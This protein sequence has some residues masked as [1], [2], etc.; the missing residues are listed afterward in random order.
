MPVLVYSLIV[1]ILFAIAYRNVPRIG[2][3]AYGDVQP[4]AL[5][6]QASLSSFSNAWTQAGLGA[7]AAFGPLSLFVALFLGFFFN[8]FDLVQKIFLFSLFPLSYVTS[9]IL[10][11]SLIKS[12]L[13]ICFA[14]FAYSINPLTLSEFLGGAQGLLL[15]YATLPLL[16]HLVMKL[17]DGPSINKVLKPAILAAFTCAFNF[18][19]PAIFAPVLGGFLLANSSG[20]KPTER[21]RSFKYVILFLA[22][23]GVAEALTVW[24][25]QSLALL[26]TVASSDFLADYRRLSPVGILLFLGPSFALMASSAAISCEKRLVPLRTHLLSASIVIILFM[27]S[28]SLGVTA[29]LFRLLPFLLVYRASVKLLYP[30]TFA[31]IML[32]AIF[33]DSVINLKVPFTK[34]WKAFVGFGRP[35]VIVLLL[36][37]PVV[38][39]NG[40]QFLTGNLGLANS[41]QI[42]GVF[43]Q[44]RS[45]LDANGSGGFFR[46]LWLPQDIQTDYALRA[47]DPKTFILPSGSVPNL[48]YSTPTVSFAR[49]V[50]ESAT[51]ASST[52]IGQLLSYAAVKYIV[53]NLDSLQVSSPHVQFDWLTYYGE[54]NPILYKDILEGQRD[55]RLVE[56]D[57]HFVV[58]E[59][60]DFRPHVSVYNQ[61][62][63]VEE[64]ARK[65]P[66]TVLANY[67]QNLVNNPSFS[68]N[69]SGW[70]ILSGLWVAGQEGE[71]SFLLGVSEKPWAFVAQDIAVEANS[72]F[73]FSA[74]MRTASALQSHIKIEW[75]DASNHWLGTTFCQTGIDG[76]KDWFAVSKIVF[77][78]PH[79]S[80]ARL[81]LGAGGASPGSQTG[82]TWFAQPSLRETFV[83]LP[84]ES[85]RFESSLLS[86]FDFN[87]TLTVHSLQLDSNVLQQLVNSVDTV[88][89]QAGSGNLE[90]FQHGSLGDQ[91]IRHELVVAGGVTNFMPLDGK[92]SLLPDA[93]ASDGYLATSENGTTSTIFKTDSVCFCRISLK[94]TAGSIAKLYVDRNLTSLTQSYTDRTGFL[95]V[96]SAGMSLLPGF[97]NVTIQLRGE[98]DFASLYQIN[99]EQETVQQLFNGRPS[100][101]HVSENDP[102]TSVIDTSNKGGSLLV[103]AENY[104]IAWEA[105]TDH[106]TLTHFPGLNRYAWGNT[107]LLPTSGQ[108]IV[109]I[110][111]SLQDSRNTLIIGYLVFWLLLL[112]IAATSVCLW[113]ARSSRRV[114]RLILRGLRSRV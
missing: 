60:L 87:Q 55:L 6:W 88:L 107:F 95:W 47:F 51:N 36:V 97:H 113:F 91:R 59:N 24:L 80:V 79:A 64:D 41:T 82:M 40:N 65:N 33:M 84:Y 46:T 68:G 114:R 67:T 85:S 8:N 62:L 4:W 34:T 42:D 9:V 13:V 14:S 49:N 100:L 112:G 70:Q 78:P 93:Q 26:S 19:A 83:R 75:H 45:W 32:T 57:K 16:S 94:L 31:F 92:W 12:N 18:Q 58:Y 30:L 73:L 37:I 10:L 102:V 98:L 106:G 2:I 90:L 111:F 108:Q 35:S 53:L 17:R 89:V 21:M 74:S 5:S 86:S 103:L 72:S 15:T 101:A 23:T 99:N 109:V 38:L 50:L 104:D 76:S 25:Q 105:R 52:N 66:P 69:L 77:S 7:R 63:V 11:R 81:Y 54:G 71:R 48:N 110:S 44:A 56:T 43:E 61:L 22:I 28:T 96:D 39:Y 29:D 20:K 1:F 27:Y 3:L